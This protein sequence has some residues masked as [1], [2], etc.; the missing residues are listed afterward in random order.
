MRPF[1]TAIYVNPTGSGHFYGNNSATGYFHMELLR[2]PLGTAYCDMVA[3]TRETRGILD[4]RLSE[5]KI[6][7]TFYLSSSVYSL[8]LSLLRAVFT[9][10]SDLLRAVFTFLIPC[11]VVLRAVLHLNFRSATGY[12]H[13]ATGCFHLHM[14][15]K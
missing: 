1:L 2:S 9:R 4:F 3:G 7:F 10:F 13:F 6:T 15:E 5:I 8:S 12:F 11:Y 14:C